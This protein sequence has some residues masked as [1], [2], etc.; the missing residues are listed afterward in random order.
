[1]RKK[2]AFPLFL[3]LFSSVIVFAQSGQDK[4]DLERERQEIRNELKDI[5]DQ[6]KKLKGKT[7]QNLV[8]WNILKKK[9]AVQEKYIS[10]INKEIRSIDDDIYRSNLEIYRLQKQT[11]TLKSQY[12]KT[13]VYAYK[14]RSNYDYLNFIFSA[15]GFNDAIKRISYLKSYRAYR[16]KQVGTILETQKLISQRQ[17][18]Q[19]DRK[20]DKSKSLE[21]QTKQVDELAAQKKEKDEVVSELKSQ[22]KVLKKEIAAKQKKDKDLQSSINAVVR[23]EI[24]ASRKE[25]R[26]RAAEVARIKAENAAREKEA[27]AAAKTNTESTKPATTPRVVVVESSKPIV[28]FNTDEDLKLNAGFE[29]NR[30]RLPWPVDNGLVKIHYGRYNIEGTKIIG[31]NPGI[32]IST[33]AG[34]AVKAVFNGEV[35]AITSAGDGMMI[36]IRHG[37]YFTI[38]S[39]ITGV[40]VNKHETVTTGQYLG[41]AGTDDDG[42][43]GQIEFILMNEMNNINPQPWLH[44]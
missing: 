12:E 31:D 38:Y 27:T 34:S 25:A 30:G 20:N 3:F 1:M 29:G 32:T 18:Q 11:D 28:V 44:R 15:N 7:K 22:E 36:T 4:S 41:R 9:I 2:I 35:V 14:N 26:Q 6:Y 19:L 42:S 8:Q 17:K 10:N 24:E 33:D 39:N 43:N 21:N 16:E 13:V 5:Q 23:R 40:A 37:K